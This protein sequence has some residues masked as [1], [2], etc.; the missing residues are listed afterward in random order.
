MAILMAAAIAPVAP[1][2]AQEAIPAAPDQAGSTVARAPQNEI[3]LRR[4]GDR[5]VPVDPVVAASDQPALHRDGSAA[6]PFVAEVGRQTGLAD[7][8]FDWSAAMIGAGAA[9]ALM[10]LG[11]GTFVLVRRS[12]PHM[13]RGE[14]PTRVVAQ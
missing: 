9:F 2:A 12:Q 13:R 10:L 1:A 14:T 3:L 11:M 6:V 8:S 7:S 5:A 4:D